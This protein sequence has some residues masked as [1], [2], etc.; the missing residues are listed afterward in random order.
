M[1]MSIHSGFNVWLFRASW[2]ASVLIGI[3]LLVQWLFRKQL[4]PRWRYILWLLVVVRLAMPFS[5]ESGLSIFNFVKAGWVPEKPKVVA[6]DAPAKTNAANNNLVSSHSTDATRHLTGN[7]DATFANQPETTATGG[8]G[9]SIWIGF[10]KRFWMP[11][12]IGVWL[13]GMLALPLYLIIPTVRLAR[14]IRRQR[15]MTN[16][17][18]LS[19]LEDCKQLMGV[20]LPLVV[21]ETKEITSPALYGCIRPRLLLPLGLVDRFTNQE[22]RFVFLHELA[23]IKRHDIAINWLM[24]ALQM[25]HWFNPLVWLAF[26]RMRADR[27]LACD[28]MALTYARD[29]EAKPYGRTII[30]LLEGFARP[31]AAPTLL[32]ILEDQ[33]QMK[34]RIGMIAQFR[35]PNRWPF[36]AVGLL[37]VLTLVCLTDARNA[38]ST[39]IAEPGQSLRAAAGNSSRGRGSSATSAGAFS[40]PFTKAATGGMSLLILDADTGAPIPHAVL[41]ADYHLVKERRWL[42][43]TNM[44]TDANG[45]VGVRFPTNSYEAFFIYINANHHV[46]RLINWGWDGSVPPRSYTMRMNKGITIGGRVKNEEGKPIAGAKV[47]VRGPSYEQSSIGSEGYGYQSTVN[48]AKTDA[49]GEWSFDQVPPDFG[50]FILILEHPDYAKTTFSTDRNSRAEGYLPKASM[51]ALWSKDAVLV[52]KRGQTV[53]GLVINAQ[54]QPIPRARVRRGLLETTGDEAGHFYFYHVI[55]GRMGLHVSADGYTET[56]A[57]FEITNNMPEIQVQLEQAALLS[58]QVVDSKGKPI[59][60]ATVLLGK[61]RYQAMDHIHIS[62]EHGGFSF[63]HLPKN[64]DDV[65]LTVEAE[66]FAPD[67]ITVPATSEVSQLRIQLAKGR[68]LRGVVVDADGRPI[69]NADVSVLS[70]REHQTILWH[71]R[72]DATGRFCWN[73]APA[74]EMQGLIGRFF[75]NIQ[76][77]QSLMAFPFKAGEKEQTF[78]LLPGPPQTSAER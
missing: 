61:N 26:H 55:P 54:G 46:P 50:E 7:G 48:W 60:G 59:S 35:R 66:G 36:L 53:T 19:L 6:A 78:T 31:A 16:P 14:K 20:S 23:H 32:G 22:L 13:T 44:V 73:S 70:W 51:N 27:E 33:R 68:I 47:I 12:M 18:V 58:G 41:N 24:A 30:K 52:L 77:D 21:I 67:L 72:T 75:G 5:T 45:A 15:S 9:G 56:V 25:L 2:Q 76:R 4:T 42:H 17:V 71:A 38:S 74:E 29:D 39:I 40:A 1:G 62:D 63:T 69:V 65:V 11:A 10:V 3:V 37:V 64:G 57:K 8:Q 34:Q 43:V 28:A 49:S